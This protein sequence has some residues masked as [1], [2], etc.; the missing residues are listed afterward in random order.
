[1]GTRVYFQ[2]AA[3]NRQTVIGKR[4]MNAD[5]VQAVRKHFLSWSGGFQPESEQEIFVYLEYARDPNLGNEDEVR[6]MLREW[7]ET[8][9]DFSDL[10][11][12][13][14]GRRRGLGS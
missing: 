3:R 8:E 10:R 7:M 6:L 11:E 9:P 2:S 1:M 5:L 12:F 14:W 13:I 4:I